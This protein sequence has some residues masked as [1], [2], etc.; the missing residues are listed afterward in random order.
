[1]HVFNVVYVKNF[2]TPRKVLRHWFSSC[3]IL[4][5]HARKDIIKYKSPFEWEKSERDL[6]KAVGLLV[7]DSLRSSMLSYEISIRYFGNTF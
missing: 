1:M 3:H 6:L 5:Q 4:L 7:C 2:Q